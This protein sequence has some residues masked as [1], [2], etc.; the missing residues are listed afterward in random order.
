MSE[1]QENIGV[2]SWCDLTVEKAEDV[3]DFYREVVGWKASPVSMGD[4]DDFC[5]NPP[6]SDQP[7]AGICHARGVNADLPAQWL[8]YIIVADLDA[9]I[10]NCIKL[11][12]KIIAGPKNMGDAGRYCIIQDPAGAVAALYEKS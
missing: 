11:G 4:Y 9:S 10:A 7:S 6:K 12:G 8:I 5:M 2:I 1:N 3:R